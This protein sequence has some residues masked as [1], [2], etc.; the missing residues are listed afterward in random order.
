MIGGA[1]HSL[2]Q[3]LVDL[4]K[5]PTFGARVYSVNRIRYEEVSVPTFGVSRPP[6]I[7]IDTSQSYQFIKLFNSIVAIHCKN[8]VNYTLNLIKIL[9]GI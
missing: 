1:H 7:T 5:Y 6:T 9:E 3:L 8:V 4:Y 2:Q